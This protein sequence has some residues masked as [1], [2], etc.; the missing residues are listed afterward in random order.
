MY[1]VTIII[2][3]IFV[4]A[5]GL[6]PNIGAQLTFRF[7]AGVFGATPLT[8][9]GGSI[10]DI[11]SPLEKTFAFPLYAIPGFAGV[12]LG[13]VIAAYII[14][15]GSWRWAEWIV[16][17]ISALALLWIVLFQP[18]TYHP[19]LL[20]WKAEH[21]RK[22]TGDHRFRA[23]L[24]IIDL[25]LWLRLKIALMRAAVLCIEPI[26]LAMTLYLTVL[27]IVLFTFLDGYPVIFQDVYG[28]S[29]GLSNVI[30][31]GLYVG[32]LMAGL[33]I[34]WIYKITKRSFADNTFVPE[35]RL[36]FAML[37]APAM[38]IGL[39]WMAWTDFVSLPIYIR[40]INIPKHKLT[41]PKGKYNNL[42]TNPSI[43]PNR[44]RHHLYLHDSLHVHHRLLRDLRR[45]SISIRDIHALRRSW[46]YDGGRGPVLCECGSEVDVDCYGVY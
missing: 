18:E 1:I 42:V 28:V 4:M 37:G 46:W 31:T 35:I 38:P 16:L 22:E 45:F 5:S 20:M 3:M 19:L 15:L 44:L 7:L 39:F 30:F 27:Y 9:A 36:W 17:I 24:E 26:V 10:S 25:S 8:C 29:Q 43:R 40:A 34:P 6:A 14:N 12:V 41:T 23:E 32:M 13:P 21:L 11:W 2:Y 33:L